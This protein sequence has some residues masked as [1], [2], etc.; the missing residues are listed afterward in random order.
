MKLWIPGL[1]IAAAMAVLIAVSIAQMAIPELQVRQVLAGE[2]PN[3]HIKMHGRIKAIHQE[4]NPL[5]F[6]ICDKDDA[7]LMVLAEIDAVR[8]DLFKVDNDVAVEGIFDPGTGKIRGDKIYTKCPSKYVASDEMGQSA[9]SQGPGAP[10]ED[11]DATPSAGAAA[12]AYR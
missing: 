5:L 12:P 7:N 4:F 11:S 3:V 9:A 1:A 10:R 6:E 8:P 2:K